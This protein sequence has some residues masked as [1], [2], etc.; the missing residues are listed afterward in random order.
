V[1]YCF[2]VKLDVGPEPIDS[3]MESNETIAVQE[4]SNDQK[5]QLKLTEQEVREDL[6][7]NIVEE[8]NNGLTHIGSITL[9][10]GSVLYLML[11]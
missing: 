10:I 3:L 5:Q 7:Y 6:V 9:L 8:R 11:H 4:I 1:R 2:K